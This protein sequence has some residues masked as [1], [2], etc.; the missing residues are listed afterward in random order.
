M[1]LLPFILVEIERRGLDV[2][3]TRWCSMNYGREPT[4]RV[5]AAA[6]R[7]WTQ[8][9]ITAL[10]SIVGDGST[11]EQIAVKLDRTSTDVAALMSRLRLRVAA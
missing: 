11:V 7:R 8:T 2:S 10:R 3:P 4:T 6:D 9:D 5:S 1:P